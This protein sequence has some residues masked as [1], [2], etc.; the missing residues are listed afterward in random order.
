MKLTKTQLKEL[1]Q[2][3]ISEAY[4]DKKAEFQEY[5]LSKYKN[6]SIYGKFK[7]SQ[8]D[9]S[10]ALTWYNGKNEIYATPFWEGGDILPIDVQDE[11]G[12][13]VYNKTYKFTYYPNQ[14]RMEMEYFKILNPIVKKFK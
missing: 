9:H 10:G 11:D 7:L 6:K 14:I 2:E 3:V 5:L 13:E 1:I 8:D 4:D 12:N